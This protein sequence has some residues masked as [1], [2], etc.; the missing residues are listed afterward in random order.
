MR[1]DTNIDM[2]VVVVQVR[3]REETVMGSLAKRYLPR[4]VHECERKVRYSAEDVAKQAETEAR[5]Q[6]PVSSVQS[7][8]SRVQDAEARAGGQGPR[9]S[10]QRPESSVEDA[11]SKTGVR[12]QD[13]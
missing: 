12:G 1:N 7:P 11:E 5:G 13:I 4:S 6:G 8:V 3:A 2:D 10:V 9:S